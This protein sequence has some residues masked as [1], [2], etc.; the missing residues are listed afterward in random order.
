[1]TNGVRTWIS[2]P[3]I[4]Y[5]T[6]PTPDGRWLL[7][8]LISASKI[9]VVDLRSMAV[10]RSLDV[11]KAPQEVLV[12][13]DGSE[14]YVSCD[15]SHQVAVLDLRSWQVARLVTAGAGTDGLGWAKR[16]PDL[17]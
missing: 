5:G 16:R 14:A 4:G 8:A 15:A 2:L 13:P 9:G 7:V 3:G 6:A 10:V 1:M 17:R 11:P 12:R